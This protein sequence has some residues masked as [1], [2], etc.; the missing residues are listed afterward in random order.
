MGFDNFTLGREYNEDMFVT[1]GNYILLE[2]NSVSSLD[3]KALSSQVQES[4]LKEPFKRIKSVSDIK[5]GHSIDSYCK[6]LYNLTNIQQILARSHR[7]DFYVQFDN[8][9]FFMPKAEDRAS[10]VWSKN[11]E[12]IWQCM[13]ALRGHFLESFQ[14]SSNENDFSGLPFT[15]NSHVE[16]VS[17]KRS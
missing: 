7:E 11:E 16:T 12:G 4:L 17:I 8:A 9:E 10:L 1:I 15:S 3:V 14:I 13:F 5:D 6:S 2:N